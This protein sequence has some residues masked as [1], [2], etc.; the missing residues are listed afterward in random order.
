M[1]DA[2]QQRWFVIKAA[3]GFENKVAQAL[4]EKIKQQHLEAHFGQILVPTESI[5][6]LRA[7]QKRHSNRKFFPGYLLIQMSLTDETWQLIRHLPKV[8]GFVGGTFEKPAPLAD[9]EV[10]G[11]L[12]RLKETQDKPRHKY[13]FEPGEEIRVCNGPFAEFK[14]SVERVDY[15]KDRLHVLI[16]I[17]G[18]AT[19][20]EL[21]FQDVTKDP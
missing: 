7:G 10:A 5:V 18:R 21:G 11:I 4:R 14:G 15:A 3:T 6:E 8:S 2:P 19:P 12:S 13:L 17:F 9:S 1:S 16:S 20:I